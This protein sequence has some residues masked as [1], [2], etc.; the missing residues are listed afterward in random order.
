MYKSTFNIKALA[1]FDFDLSSHIFSNGD[2]H[3]K[4]YANNHFWQ[5]MHVNQ[6]IIFLYV[7]SSGDLENPE[8]E[9]SVESKEELSLKILNLI[10]PIVHN[11]F[12]LGLDLRPFY[13]EMEKD[14]VMSKIVKQLYGLKNPSTP[15]LFEAIVDSIIEQQ[16][17][18][19]AAHSIENRVIK[20]FGSSIELYKQK[21]YS[22]PRPE[23]LANLELQELRDCGLS[24]R[25][26]E[27][28]RDLSQNILNNEV[29]FNYIQNMGSTHEMI[30]EIIKIRGIGVWTAE[31]GLLRGLGRLDAIPA[32]DIGLQRVISHF[33]R[34]NEKIS[35]EELRKIA[36]SWG[37]WKGLASYY[38]I[39]AD[40]MNIE[41]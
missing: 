22:Y 12:N 39:V 17:S 38:L 32:D 20:S 9:V 24:F 5:A 28:I 40:M 3:I 15:T 25:K 7:E 2:K 34:D 31:L 30:Q 18:L 33:Y 8:L 1:P 11:I 36:S 13:Q 10:P 6:K 23:D 4:K 27:Y 37:K 29:D 26:A 14:E 21:Y 16:I 41:I 35:S 19:K